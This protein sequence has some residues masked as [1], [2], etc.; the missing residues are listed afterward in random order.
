MMLVPKDQP[1][2]EIILY[3]GLV[4]NLSSDVGTTVKM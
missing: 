1:A 3:R 4:N 2:S